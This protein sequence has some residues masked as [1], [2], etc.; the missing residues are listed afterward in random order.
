MSGRSG[1]G[2]AR[3]SGTQ[4]AIRPGRF[5][6]C[7][8]ARE[9]LASALSAAS[10]CALQARS[11]AS[12]RRGDSMA[13]TSWTRV[14]CAAVLAAASLF[15]TAAGAASPVNVQIT[16]EGCRNDGTI[17]FPALGP[18]ICP[19]AAYTSGNLGKGWNELDLV[20]H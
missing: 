18:F 5:E 19:D 6:R 17:T 8:R 14:T 2:R 10:T 16:L 20:P 3:R 11:I 9:S 13:L 4:C 1:P 12:L 15:G 7:Q